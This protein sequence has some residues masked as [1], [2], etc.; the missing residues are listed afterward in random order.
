MEKQV[1]RQRAKMAEQNK[2]LE[3]LRTENNEMSSL[4][5]LQY[6]YRLDL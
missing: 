2:E 3:K 1:E 4:K 6:S 5:V